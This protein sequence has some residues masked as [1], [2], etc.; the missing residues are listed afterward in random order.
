MLQ[1]KVVITTFFFIHAIVVIAIAVSVHG[2]AIA[3][4]ETVACK[5]KTYTCRMI[6]P[7]P[8]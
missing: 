5:K 3:V 4:H 6:R 7:K 8:T 2:I 1:L